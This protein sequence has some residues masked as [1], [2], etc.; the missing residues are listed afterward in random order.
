MIS[1]REQCREAYRALGVYRWM[2]NRTASAALK[3][4]FATKIISL[5]REI[6]SYTG[7]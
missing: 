1:D 3:E 6:R 5:K 7:K 2:E 4:K